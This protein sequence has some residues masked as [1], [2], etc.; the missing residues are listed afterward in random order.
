M[1]TC[2]CGGACSVIAT[3]AI[4]FAASLAQ[5]VAHVAAIDGVVWFLR[6]R[7]G[8]SRLPDDGELSK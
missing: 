1:Q 5:F 8:A 7:S 2:C 4:L 6:C 3:V